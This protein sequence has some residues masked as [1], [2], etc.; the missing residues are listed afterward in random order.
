MVAAVHAAAPDPAFL[1]RALAALV[2]E[3]AYWTSEPKQVRDG[4]AGPRTQT[5]CM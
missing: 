1:H 5:M 2:C 3:H 4:A